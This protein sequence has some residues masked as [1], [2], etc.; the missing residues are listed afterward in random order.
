MAVFPRH[1]DDRPPLDHLRRHEAAVV[2]VA[3][4]NFTW[5]RQ[6]WE[7][8]LS[9]KRKPP[10]KGALDDTR[11]SL[12]SLFRAAATV[13]QAADSSRL[14]PMT[15]LVCHCAQVCAEIMDNFA[16]VSLQTG[17]R[18]QYGPRFFASGSIIR[19]AISS[20]VQT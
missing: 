5:T 4:Q 20:S 15:S 13:F 8:Q 16:V 10:R 9:R 17:C 6:I 19:A 3:N 2:E 12:E 7:H 1:D 18:A 14:S 11:F